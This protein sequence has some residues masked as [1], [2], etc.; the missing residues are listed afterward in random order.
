M[1]LNDQKIEGTA[2]AL[3]IAGPS[4]GSDDNKKGLSPLQ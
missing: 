1:L 4:S 3:Q 2:F